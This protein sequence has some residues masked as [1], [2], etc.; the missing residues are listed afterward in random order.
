M[1]TQKVTQPVQN[2]ISQ[3][4]KNR[5]K[6]NKRKNKKSAGNGLAAPIA[7]SVEP[8]VTS[9]ADDLSLQKTDDHPPIDKESVSLPAVNLPVTNSFLSEISTE[10][11]VAFGS[12]SLIDEI[13]QARTFKPSY[14]SG[15]AETPDVPE[16]GEE[17]E[18][19]ITKDEESIKPNLV[20][21]PEPVTMET[22]ID[23]EKDSIDTLQ[24]SMP[25]GHLNEQSTNDVQ[26][27]SELESHKVQEDTLILDDTSTTM[28]PSDNERNEAFTMPEASHMSDEEEEEPKEEKEHLPKND[29]NAISQAK[30]S[31]PEEQMDKNGG[32]LS[33]ESK[34][35]S[36][37]FPLSAD[38][39]DPSSSPP[40]EGVSDIVASAIHSVIASGSIDTESIV[41]KVVHDIEQSQKVEPRSVKDDVMQDISGSRTVVSSNVHKNEPSIEVCDITEGAVQ[42]PEPAVGGTG[43]RM[44]S[45]MRTPDIPK[46]TPTDQSQRKSTFAAAFRKRNCI[47]L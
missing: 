22:P 31:S 3:Q 16:K 32:G 43:Q 20:V 7:N 6:K 36:S 46:I 14:A 8:N 29:P 21:Q 5:K 45:S 12:N 41:Q 10:L 24:H 44:P 40:A 15:A 47:I 25:S 4:S 37:E 23:D 19:G 17:S 26:G 27:E 9:H 11:D 30:E 38:S 1:T 35:K 33:D 28:T 42:C 2:P 34:N 18:Q 13:N 39:N